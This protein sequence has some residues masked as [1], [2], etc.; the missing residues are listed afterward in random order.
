MKKISLWCPTWP[1]GPEDRHNVALGKF[2]GSIVRI[3]CK[4]EKCAEL[5]VCEGGT[6]F[7]L[8][9]LTGR[10]VC[11][12]GPHTTKKSAMDY[13]TKRFSKIPWQSFEDS[14]ADHFKEVLQ[15]VSTDPNLN[16]YLH[17]SMRNRPWMK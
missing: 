5:L 4:G 6:W 7:I 15:D 12:K 9:P 3:K 2:E 10:R 14:V 13:V 16:N 1:G 8:E 11:G 17:Y